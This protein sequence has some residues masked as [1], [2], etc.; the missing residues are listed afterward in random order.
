MRNDTVI[1]ST[2]SR[3]VG[4][5]PA[6]RPIPEHPDALLHTA[7]AGFL[8]GLSARTLEA[9]RLRGGGPPY[10]AV[11]PK[12]IRYRRQDLERWIAERR[13]VS[14]SDA[15]PSRDGAVSGRAGT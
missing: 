9:L 12:A 15:G 11:T 14:T 4:E 3:G 6:G 10:I 8:L 1:A 5:Q 2:A 13:R 7:E